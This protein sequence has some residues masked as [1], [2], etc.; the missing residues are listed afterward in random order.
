M[1]TK[2]VPTYQMPS[3]YDRQAAE[4]RRRQAMAEALEAQ[5]YR[6]LSG[7]DAPTPAAAPLVMAL[8]SFMSARQRKKAMEEATK[9]EETES[10]YGRRMLGR[11]QGGYAYQPDK[12]LE[13]QMAKKPEETL[14]QYNERMQATPFTAKAAAVPEQTELGEVTRQSQYRKS[15]D[16][17]LGMAMT[18][19]GT[20]AMKRAPLLAAALERSMTPAEA[21]EYYAPTATSDGNLV[22]F[23]KLGGKK[24]TGFK[25]PEEPSKPPATHGNLQWNAALKKWES[26][27]GYKPPDPLAGDRVRSAGEDRLRREFDNAIKP[28]LDELSQIGKVKTIF[29]SVPAGG[30]PNAIQQDVLVTLL[31]KF[32]EPGSVVREGEYDRLVSRQ[33]LVARAQT[34]LNKVQTGE[35]LTGE[36]LTQIAGLARLFEEA[37]T[38]RVRKKAANISTLAGNRQLDVNNIILEPS[39]LQKPIEIGSSLSG[40]PQ[41]KPSWTPELQ[42]ELDALEQKTKNP[43]GGR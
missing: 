12:E 38:N 4:A 3:E 13:Q 29:Q 23:G 22:Q 35:P 42:S 24:E 25:T 11:L 21:E 8:Q 31:M 19:V 40:K 26:I 5:A 43:P 36:A 14:T 20:A 7:S 10:E 15:P 28:D 34:L 39:F 33:G 6:P 41:G 2:F 32:I 17:V 18:P 30:K 9:A 27:P 37:A 16:E 1:Q